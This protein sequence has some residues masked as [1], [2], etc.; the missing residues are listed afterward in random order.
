MHEPKDEALTPHERAALEALPR[1]RKPSALLEE[2]TVRALRE[3]GLLRT[4]GRRGARAPWRL[5]AAAAAIALF[6]AGTAFGQWLG[7]RQ[8][9]DTIATVQRD[10]AMAAAL[11]VQRAGTA[12]LDA[13]ATLVTAAGEA[14]PTVARQAREVALAV[15][16]GASEE[17]G[18]LQ[19]QDSSAA[20]QESEVRHVLWF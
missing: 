1:E 18:R 2:R 16:R 5:A 3:R 15:Y 14:D 12:Y 19:Q 4:P 6:A 7:V 11:Q 9:A 10:D 17:I 20:G 8:A 13:L